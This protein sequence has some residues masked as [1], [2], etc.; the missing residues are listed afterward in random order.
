MKLMEKL[1]LFFSVAA[2]SAALVL[3]GSCTRVHSD[4]ESSVPEDAA[5]V[6]K[7]D[8]ESV[9]DD[10]GL[11]NSGYLDTVKDLILSSVDDERVSLKLKE[12]LRDISNTGLD[13]GKAVYLALP[14][15][16]KYSPVAVIAVKDYNKLKENCRFFEAETDELRF[17]DEGDNIFSLTSTDL[18]F[19]A[20]FDKDAFVLY[21]DDYAGNRDDKSFVLSLLEQDNSVRDPSLDKLFSSRD[22]ICAWYSVRSLSSYAGVDLAE[23]M[24]LSSDDDTD[25]MLTVDTKGNRF[26][27][28]V[29]AEL[30][31]SA[32]VLKTLAGNM[33]KSIF[34][35]LPANGLLSAS[36]ALSSF[37][38][39]LDYLPLDLAEDI[40]D[41]L[42]D[43]GLTAS[44]FGGNAAFTL[45]DVDVDNP[46]F[47]L[48]ANT[49]RVVYERLKGEL[50]D[51]GMKAYYDDGILSI[52]DKATASESDG[53]VFRDNISGS[54]ASKV[55]S[56]ACF[57]LS[58]DF[59]TL[60][61]SDVEDLLDMSGLDEWS[62]LLRE[63]DILGKLGTASVSLSADPKIAFSLTLREK[64]DNIWKVI[65]DIVAGM[66]ADNE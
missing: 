36:L 61:Y 57:S 29:D 30:G 58:V 7:V 3:T 50:R 25:C 66:I 41:A 21:L 23:L 53:G 49:D 13:F 22:Q 62:Y 28:V 10:S 35:H 6:V 2:V 48:A 15:N 43:A 33:D 46:Q 55:M 26:D 19:L 45:L 12:F 4:Y 42:E 64:N 54:P 11:E 47:A 40:D 16:E 37:N 27:V 31:E 52:M 56:D 17:D 60:S 63:T 1:K 24:G 59:Q 32:R 44:D 14:G 51:L 20:A 39:A 8:L 5:M 65:A 9:Y 18:S 38:R 34:K